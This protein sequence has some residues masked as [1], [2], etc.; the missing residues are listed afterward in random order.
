MLYENISASGWRPRGDIIYCT[1]ARVQY[2]IPPAAVIS[3]YISSAGH[4]R[5]RP[6]IF[7][8]NLYLNEPNKSS[9]KGMCSRHVKWVKNAKNERSFEKMTIHL[10]N[11]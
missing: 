8:V 4:D 2:K 11:F 10:G 7:T 6:L 5:R 1:R 9:P 3:I